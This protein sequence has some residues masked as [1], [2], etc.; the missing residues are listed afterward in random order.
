MGVALG[1]LCRRG[2]P[3]HVRRH[4]RFEIRSRARVSIKQG[5]QNDAISD[6]GHPRAGVFDSALAPHPGKRKRNKRGNNE[7]RGKGSGMQPELARRT[8]HPR[9]RLR[10]RLREPESVPR[11]APSPDGGGSGDAHAAQVT[12]RQPSIS[13]V[14][15]DGT[16]N[17]GCSRQVRQAGRGGHG[18]DSRH[19]GLHTAAC[20]VRSFRGHWCSAE[21]N[22]PRRDTRGERN[23]LPCQTLGR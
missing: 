21:K 17:G 2:A 16:V 20:Q 3:W 11:R 7:R 23:A 6:V 5:A 8:S 15:I 10:V 18:R 19:G 4:S 22:I 14:G 1:L 9:R 12:A 13:G